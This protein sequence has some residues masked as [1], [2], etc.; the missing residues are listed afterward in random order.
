M[1]KSVNP[2]TIGDHLIQI[3]RIALMVGIMI[4]LRT[5][6]LV[7]LNDDASGNQNLDTKIVTLT[8]KATFLIFGLGLFCYW[9][10]MQIFNLG[11]K[12]VFKCQPLG[13]HDWSFLLDNDDNHHIIVVVGI[14][15]KFD[16][17]SMKM[18]IM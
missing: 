13:L 3:V 4:K 11:M 5:A 17:V 18:H 14:F 6:Y 10:L 16:Y 7:Y 2:I 9:L 8:W 12:I 1:S 15:E